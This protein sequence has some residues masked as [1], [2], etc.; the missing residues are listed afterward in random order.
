[1]VRSILGVVVGFA[2][3]SAMWL[4]GQATLF[5]GAM[6]VVAAGQ[7]YE[8]A[9]VLGGLVVYSVV[10]SVVSGLVCALIARGSRAAAV[11][12]AVLLLAVGVGFEVSAWGL[13]PV[14]SHLVFLVLL[15]PATLI[16]ARIGWGAKKVPG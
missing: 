6:K 10:C 13:T 9:P 4:A 12:L 14:W 1:M 2:L 11:V 3:W 16:G 8:D 7:R 5:A 15:V